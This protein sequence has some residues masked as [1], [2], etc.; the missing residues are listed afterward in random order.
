VRKTETIASLL[1]ALRNR[2]EIEAAGFAYGGILLG[3]EDTVGTFVPPGS[4]LAEQQADTAKPRLKSISAGYLRA[5]GVPLLAGRELDGRDTAAAPL[6]VLV[7]RTVARRYF[8]DA[9]P[10]G[11]TMT[12]HLPN[13]PQPIAIVG[14]VEDVRQGRVAVPPY[15][16]IFMDYRQVLEVMRR[17]GVSPQQQE[18]L[19][20][21][22][23]SFGARTR[24]SPEAAMPSIRATVRAVDANA[25]IDAI[26]TMD[27][28]VSNSM[29]RQRFY[30]VLLGAFAAIAGLLAAIGIYGVLAYS[31]VQRTPE[32]GVRMALGAERRQ[33][34]ALVLRRGLVLSVI[35]ITIGLA[36]AVAG[37]RYLR[38]MLFGIDALDPWTFTIVAASFILVA[39]MASYLPARR[40]TRVEP[41]VALRCD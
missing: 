22:F 27:H 26:H 30:A 40:A 17:A 7:N 39:A 5:M 21:G 34:L 1:L 19:A 2:P 35:G 41:V 37:A 16:Q 4:T 12:W 32:I 14:V 31:V 20:F 9:N 6:A 29:A 8:G 25:G 24:G 15:A 3:L 23:M 28:M 18:Q 33:V 11:A 36:G 13:G 10:V 38:A